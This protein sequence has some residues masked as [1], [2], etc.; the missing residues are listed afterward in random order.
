MRIDLALPNLAA[1]GESPEQAAGLR[2]L[3]GELPSLAPGQV[4]PALVLNAAPNQTLL[5]LQGTQLLLEALPG[6]TAGEELLVRLAPGASQPA[7]QVVPQAPRPA[8]LPDLRVGQELPLEILHE[9]PDGHVLID[10]Q[11]NA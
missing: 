10:L 1:A 6:L 7:L 8:G 4:V 9:F 3:A 2:V 5:Q 11:G